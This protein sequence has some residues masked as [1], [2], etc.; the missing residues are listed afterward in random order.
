[1]VSALDP[2]LIGLGKADLAGSMGNSE[3]WVIVN[4]D[5]HCW[6]SVTC[7]STVSQQVMDTLPTHYR[8]SADSVKWTKN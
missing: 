5:S 7:Q 6:L 4:N 3:Q 1:M 8:Q 2:R